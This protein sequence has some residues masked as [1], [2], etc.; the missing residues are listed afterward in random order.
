[1]IATISS[2]L[3][4]LTRITTIYGFRYVRTNETD[5]YGCVWWLDLDVR[6]YAATRAFVA[7]RCVALR[8]H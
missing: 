1:M 8:P 4:P 2:F 3:E 7:L 5:I 6:M